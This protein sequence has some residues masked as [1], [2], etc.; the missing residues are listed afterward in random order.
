MNTTATRRSPAE[1]RGPTPVASPAST[2]EPRPELPSPQ[3]RRLP[4]HGKP[5]LLFTGI[6]LGTA[7]EPAPP[8]DA[9]R[10]WWEIALYK[11]SVGA[12]LLASTYHVVEEGDRALSTVI[13]FAEAACLRDFF[14]THGSYVSQGSQHSQRST[15]APDSPNAPGPTGPTGSPISELAR[16]LLLQ[17]M[18]KD[19]SLRAAFVGF[20][21]S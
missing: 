6:L 9:R 17:A 15:D 12:Y 5:D 19:R 11:T 13:S 2:Q 1:Q 8:E 21:L 14:D 7:H 16:S 3:Y 10:N 18:A 4:R 20:V